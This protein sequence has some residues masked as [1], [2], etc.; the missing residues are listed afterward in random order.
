[1]RRLS[2]AVAAVALASC[3]AASA[4]ARTQSPSGDTCE[5]TSHGTALGVTIT[6]PT[7]AVEQGGF[8]F[9][10]PGAT[11]T[12][13]K[14]SGN[15]GTMSHDGLPASTS[16]AWVLTSPPSVP[17]GSQV[18]ASLTTSAEVTGSLTVVP[19][20]AR[21]G[22][23]PIRYLDP[24]SCSVT[25]AAPLPSN[26][27]SVHLPFSYTPASGTWN[28]YAT[29][30]GPGRLSVESQGG[31]KPLLASHT[32]AVSRAGKVN[33]RLTLS[34]AGKAAMKSRS[35]LGVRLIVEFSPKNAKPAQKTIN[36]TLRK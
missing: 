14:I 17:P 16:A 18:S 26:K 25:K 35:S 15:P 11:V 3:V 20:T 5:A 1:M 34:P 30:P 6:L 32:Y 19:A 4:D 8:A 12:A 24:I 36:I 9:G 13:I 21:T 7:N 33:V 27:F 10:A 22:G 23:A 29:V 28:S 31:T 2:T